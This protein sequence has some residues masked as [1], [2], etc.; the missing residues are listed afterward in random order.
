ML[1]FRLI[2]KK[3]FLYFSEKVVQSYYKHVFYHITSLNFKRQNP[4]FLP[5]CLKMNTK[6]T[7]QFFRF[8][9]LQFWIVA[10]YFEYP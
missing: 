6:K 5:D 10:K 9:V 1:L 4:V 7:K 2:L 8:F 3:C